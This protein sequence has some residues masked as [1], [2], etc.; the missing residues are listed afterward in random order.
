MLRP[1]YPRRGASATSD[2]VYRSQPVA[3]ANPSRP[4]VPLDR[5][6]MEIGRMGF[7]LTGGWALL[8]VLFFYFAL[9]CQKKANPPTTK[10]TTR[11]ALLPVLSWFLT[12]RK[13]QK[14]HAI[15]Q[16][17][18]ARVPI[19]LLRGRNNNSSKNKDRGSTGRSAHPPECHT[20]NSPIIP[21]LARDNG[22]GDGARLI[23]FSDSSEIRG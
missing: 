18:R 22:T 15:S 19:L 1:H 21:D 12:W 14:T 4:V 7:R 6:R 11:W 3:G 5:P 10:P 13:E 16:D 2:P 20:R 17:R 9:K 23:L 8:P